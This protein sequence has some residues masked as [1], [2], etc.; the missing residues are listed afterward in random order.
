M[1]SLLLLLLCLTAA[2]AS[3][4]HQKP[5]K[6]DS[7]TDHIYCLLCINVAS[8]TEKWIGDAGMSRR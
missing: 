6:L 1:N 5:Q 4:L 8:D 2:S 3:V 7:V